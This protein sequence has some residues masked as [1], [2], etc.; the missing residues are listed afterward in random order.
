MKYK[1]TVLDIGKGFK[2]KLWFT[3]G[4]VQ[5]PDNIPVFYGSLAISKS[6]RQLNDWFQRRSNRRVKKLQSQLTGKIGFRSMG[7][8]IR[9]VRAWVKTMDSNTVLVLKCESV[10]ADK[11]YKIWKNWFLKH[12]HTSWQ[13]KDEDKELYFYKV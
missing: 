13:F 3:F 12:E 4:Y 9:Q 7:I 10:V 2:L 8:A 6:T 1:T 11:Q 5:Q